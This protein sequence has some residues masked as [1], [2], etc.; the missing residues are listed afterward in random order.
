MSD[1][2]KA[3]QE[4]SEAPIDEVLLIRAAE[5]EKLNETNSKNYDFLEKFILFLC[6]AA[7]CGSSISELPKHCNLAVLGTGW[8][9]FLVALI[10]TL[11]QTFVSIRLHEERICEINANPYLQTQPKNQ[12]MQCWLKISAYLCIGGLALLLFSVI[13]HA[14]M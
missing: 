9:C 13:I 2:P 4:Q 5:V 14:P 11:N 8:V 6:S 12:G 3:I 10:I 7:L 1:S